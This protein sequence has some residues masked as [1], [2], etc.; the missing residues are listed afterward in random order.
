MS[1]LGW[2]GDTVWDPRESTEVTE[3]IMQTKT[4]GEHAFK[5]WQIYWNLEWKK[6][7]RSKMCV[8]VEKTAKNH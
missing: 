4:A 6:L 8:Y 1:L 3:F 5:G 2:C 7:C